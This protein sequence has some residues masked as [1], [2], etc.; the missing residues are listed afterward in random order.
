MEDDDA[1]NELRHC[2]WK[3]CQMMYNVPITLRCEIS[4]F[5]IVSVSRNLVNLFDKLSLDLEGQ[6]TSNSM[7]LAQ[8]S[9]ANDS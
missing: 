4:H 6:N 5:N 1:M 7:N 9:L 8:N 3:W 2:E